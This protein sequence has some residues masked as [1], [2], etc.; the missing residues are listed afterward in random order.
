MIHT[1]SY[2]QH[3][4]KWCD[5]WRGTALPARIDFVIV[6]AGLS[7]LATAIELR[8]R[9]SSASIAVIEAERVGYGASGRS[10]GF[11]SPVAV[12]LWLLG[13]QSDAEQA[14]AAAKINADVHAKASWLV[15]NIPDCEMQQAT[16][17]M[18]S[19]S[20]FADL[21]LGEFS[22]LLAVA[23][24]DHVKDNSGA[25]RQSIAMKAYTMHPYKLVRG[26]AQHASRC[27]IYLREHSRVRRLQSV[28]AGV[29]ITLDRDETLHAA[30]V[31][32]C[33][34]AYTAGLDLG[35]R[36]RAAALHTFMTATAAVTDHE[37][38]AA[39]RS[40]DFVVEVNRAQVYHRTHNNRIL[41]GGLDKL[42]TPAG[43][44]FAVPEKYLQELRRCAQKSFPALPHLAIEQ[45]WSGRFH[46][47]ATGLPIIRRSQAIPNLTL[48]VGYGGTGVALTL[49]CG[50]LAAAISDRGGFNDADDVRLWTLMQRTSIAP[51]DVVHSL[52]RMIRRAAHPWID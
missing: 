6:G 32:V 14:W 52:A 46:A 18:Q 38:V 44:D 28:A 39:N 40:G 4:A 17:S 43:G 12:P 36:I 2:W 30:N 31:I 20:T 33:T 23:G 27:G 7:G 41:Y 48:N 9:H 10:A 49:I 24:L 16:L 51:R 21:A 34:N 19:E 8:N 13:A 22:R 50:K 26:L 3:D 35:E 25:R 42:R 45:S 11:L 47:T 5:Q 15:T 29:Q 1:G 37:L